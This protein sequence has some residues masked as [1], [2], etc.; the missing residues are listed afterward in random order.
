MI[1]LIWRIEETKQTNKE[2]KIQTKNQTLTSREQ[3]RF[4]RGGREKGEIDEAD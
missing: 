1:S 3:T 2:K 4:L